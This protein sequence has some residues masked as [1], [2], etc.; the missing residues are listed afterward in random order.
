MIRCHNAAAN[1]ALRRNLLWFGGART[2]PTRSVCDAA[3]QTP[4]TNV[5]FIVFAAKR[6]GEPPFPTCKPPGHALSSYLRQ[7][8]RFPS[9][10]RPPT[11]FY[12]TLTVK[13]CLY[14]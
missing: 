7:P 14:T 2:P 6:A 4:S 13:V 3:A 1:T 9:T 11:H 5:A 12:G 10:L 8:R